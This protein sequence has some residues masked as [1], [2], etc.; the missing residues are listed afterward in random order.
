MKS[1]EHLGGNTYLLMND[2]QIHWFSLVL[3]EFGICM[4]LSVASWDVGIL[5]YIDDPAKTVQDS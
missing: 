2:D 5:Q 3:F 4:S 1:N